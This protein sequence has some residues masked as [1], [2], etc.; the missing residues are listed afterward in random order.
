MSVYLTGSFFS[1]DS[2]TSPNN[3][4]INVLLFCIHFSSEKTK[5]KYLNKLSY[6][7]FTVSGK[8][9]NAAGILRKDIGKIFYKEIYM[10]IHLQNRLTV[11]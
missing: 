8:A 1:E 2:N 11:C 3:P 10:N 4:K 9:E 7:T 6:I 5:K